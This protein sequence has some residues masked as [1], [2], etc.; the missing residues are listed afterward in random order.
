[1]KRTRISKKTKTILLVIV[2]ALLIVG[3]AS[4]V[5]GIFG[6][7]EKS[8]NAD[9]ERGRLSAEG[10]YEESEVTLYTP[11]GIE[12]SGLKVSFDFEHT[13]EYQIFWYNEDDLFL[14]SEAI[15]D[16]P[17][18]G[19]VP[20]LAKYCR[21]V[22]YPVLGEDEE[23]ISWWDI[24][25][26]SDCLNITVDRYQEFVPKDYYA[27][28][29]LHSTSI[30]DDTSKNISSDITFIANAML[31]T[32]EDLTAFS[33]A[34]ES[35]NDGFNVVKLNCSDI[36]AYKL[37]FDKICEGGVYHVFYFDENGEALSPAKE[38]IVKEGGYIV[39]NVPEDAVYVCFNVYPADL[40][41]GGKD[42]PIVINEYLPR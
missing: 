38:M 30:V 12:C 35:A 4:L 22:I 26:Y 28:A 18:T 42:I 24:G 16:E 29:K 40:M 32:S 5:V 21:I 3:V 8:V 33:D 2:S 19:P 1:M 31:D 11:D 17:F 7:S 34:L 6:S 15:T 14:H 39:Q 25:D 37:K 41:E 27:I 10:K 9:F 20:D 13:G 36:K 23:T